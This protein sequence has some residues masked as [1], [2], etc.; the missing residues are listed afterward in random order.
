MKNKGKSKERVD[1]NGVISHID[2]IVFEETEEGRKEAYP[3]DKIKKLQKQLKACLSEKQEYLDGWQ[4]AKADLVNFRKDEDSRRVEN[5]RLATEGVLL[6]LLPVLD[7]F[8]MAFGNTEVWERVEETWRKGI[9]HIH[10]QLLST[11]KQHG[12]EP[13]N[14]IGKRFDPTRHDSVESVA[15]E[16]KSEDNT[17]TEVLQRGYELNGKIIR[18]ARVKIAILKKGN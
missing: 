8:D 15:T 9:E 1:K 18:P 13:F 3:I 10:A 16:K 2:D 7:S 11:L 4:R 14:P 12:I 6:D 17:I 5:S